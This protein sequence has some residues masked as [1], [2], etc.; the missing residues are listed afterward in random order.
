MFHTTRRDD[1]DRYADAN[2][3][4]QDVRRTFSYAHYRIGVGEDV[5]FHCGVEVEGGTVPTRDWLRNLH[6]LTSGDLR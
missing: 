1:F 5:W 6:I 2:V 4:V 3:V